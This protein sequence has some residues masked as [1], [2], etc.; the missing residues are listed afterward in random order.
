MNYSSIIIGGSFSGILTAIYLAHER[1]DIHKRKSIC[2]IDK[3]PFF[4]KS[5]MYS[6]Y[7]Y[8]VLNVP[9]CKMSIY[10]KEPNDFVLW[11]SQKFNISDPYFFS[12]RK[13]YHQYIEDRFQQVMSSCNMHCDL[14]CDEVLDVRT[15]GENFSVITTKNIEGF[16]A[17]SAVIANGSIIKRNIFNNLKESSYHN[18]FNAW[19]FGRYTNLL[20]KQ[21]ISIIGSGLTMVD[22]VLHLD[23]IGFDGVVN[24]V[25]G[26]SCFPFAH[27]LDGLK[28]P[29]SLCWYEDGI[30]LRKIVSLVHN[31]LR[32]KTVTWQ[33][34]I[35]SIR[36][37]HLKIWTNFSSADKRRFFRHINKFWGPAR[38]RISEEVCKKFN[39]IL[40]EGKYVIKDDFA[41][42]I[43]CCHDGNY[44]IKFANNKFI[45]TDAVI[46]CTGLEYNI[47]LNKSSVLQNMMKSGTICANSI[48]I[49][50]SAARTGAIINANGEQTEGLYTLGT[51][52]IG[53]LGESIAIPEIREQARY[54]ALEIISLSKKKSNENRQ[55][56]KMVPC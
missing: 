38:H 53:V 13:Y 2:I 56:N 43:E 54:I 55:L 16:S 25:K 35:D 19:D 47:C 7:D 18:I 22:A 11:C 24:I 29:A 14:I 36:K 28:K 42:N 4:V 26:N 27:D 39:K 34:V 45:Y 31:E 9:A 20:K 44:K 5:G 51:N 52:L 23:A 12:P 1:T 15:Q 17:N 8:H 50:V 6:E 49:G 10:S 41:K 3:K 21:K 32:K 30:N 40:L 46:N 37:D 48:G 33:Q